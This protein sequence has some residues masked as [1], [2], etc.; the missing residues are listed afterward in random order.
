MTEIEETKKFNKKFNK[1]YL[2]LEKKLMRQ[3]L[4]LSKTMVK[5]ENMERKRA[6]QPPLPKWAIPMVEI[7]IL[8][9]GMEEM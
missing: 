7:D 2:K 6:N 3:M 1:K 9:G 4:K 8:S 5:M